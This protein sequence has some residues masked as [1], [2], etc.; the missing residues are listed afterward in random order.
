MRKDWGKPFTALKAPEPPA[1]LFEKIIQRLYQEQRISALRRRL[2]ILSAVLS[3]SMVALIP[4][5]RA[6]Q[7]GLTESGFME[8]FSLLFSDLAVVIAHWQDF[9]SALLE[10]LPVM[11]AVVLLSAVFV[12]LGSLKFIARDMKFIFTPLQPGHPTFQGGKEG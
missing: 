2:L 12:V 1:G 3:G 5:F 10:S 4:A 7:T 6:L 11:S 8:F 9:A